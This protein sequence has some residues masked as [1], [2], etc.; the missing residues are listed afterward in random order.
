MFQLDKAYLRLDLTVNKKPR[1]TKHI[2]KRKNKYLNRSVKYLKDT[3]TQPGAAAIKAEKLKTAKYKQ[4]QHDY[5]FVPI[6][7]ETF[8]VWGTDGAA[9]IDSLGKLVQEKSDKKNLFLTCS[10]QFLF[11]YNIVKPLAFL[12]QQDQGTNLMKFIICN[13]FFDDCS[14]NQ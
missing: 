6:A 3:V 10:N 5:Y 1:T 8:G 9:L 12:V 2:R 13:F 14:H 7:I 4:L 11:L